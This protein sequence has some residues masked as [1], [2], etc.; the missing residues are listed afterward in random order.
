M[1]YQ[2]IINLYLEEENMENKR[3]NII[4]DNNESQYATRLTF[5][6]KGDKIKLLTTQTLRMKPLI[7]PNL[8]NKKAISGF[9][10]EL[11]D[12]KGRTLFKHIEYNPIQYEVEVR[13]DDANRPF[14][15]IKVKNPSGIFTLLI[16]YFREATEVAL[17][18]SPPETMGEPA[19]EIGR[20]PMHK[21]SKNKGE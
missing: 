4:I 11:R 13:S 7:S 18:S 19:R 9:W 15:R 8:K 10:Y 12:I 6:Y 16:P 17:F 5:S 1:F 3:K 20:F 14:T 2:L 21:I